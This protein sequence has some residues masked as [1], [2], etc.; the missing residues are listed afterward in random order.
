MHGEGR[1]ADSLTNTVLIESKMCEGEIKLKT[2]ND[3]DRFKKQYLVCSD[4][5][6]N[7]QNELCGPSDD[8]RNQS[9]FQFC[10]IQYE[11]IIDS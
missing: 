6:H 1:C 7:V 2:C 8:S 4:E 3:E 9:H 5:K 10:K 11:K